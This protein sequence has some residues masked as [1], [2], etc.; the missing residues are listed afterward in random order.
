MLLNPEYFNVNSYAIKAFF[1]G[2]PSLRF[3]RAIRC[4]FPV[5]RCYDIVLKAAFRSAGS[6]RMPLLSLTRF[7]PLGRCRRQRGLATKKHKVFMNLAY[8]T[9]FDTPYKLRVQPF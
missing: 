6:G 9:C 3:G 7:S 8:A 5:P 2:V 4:I 1:L